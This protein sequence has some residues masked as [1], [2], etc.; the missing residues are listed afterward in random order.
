MPE[1]IAKV[2]AE[3]AG[4]EIKIATGRAKQRYLDNM[5]STQEEG[6]SSGEDEDCCILCKCEFSRG[7]ITGW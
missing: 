4:L 6:A 7:Y 5:A 2:Q 3:R 1:A